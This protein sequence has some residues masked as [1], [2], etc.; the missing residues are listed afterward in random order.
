MNTQHSGIGKQPKATPAAE[1]L[2]NIG[3]PISAESRERASKM[4]KS[5][6][7]KNSGDRYNCVRDVALYLEKDEPHTAMKKAMGYVDLTGAY[8]LFAEL[9]I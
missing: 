2:N 7:M 5:I 1:P 8:R 4:L 9:L 6:G 3:K